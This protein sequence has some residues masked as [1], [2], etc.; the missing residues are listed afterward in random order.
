MLKLLEGTNKYTSGH[1]ILNVMC[2]RKFNG[3]LDIHLLPI[4]RLHLFLVMQVS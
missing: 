3:V 4:T 1:I 2:T